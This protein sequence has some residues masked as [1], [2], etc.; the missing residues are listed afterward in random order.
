MPIRQSLPRLRMKTLPLRRKMSR[1]AKRLPTNRPRRHRKTV[2]PSWMQQPAQ[3]SGE[4]DGDAA[5]PLF[6]ADPASDN[7]ADA[8]EEAA[9]EHSAAHEGSEE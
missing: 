7:N 3:P 2:R 5:A 9:E 1:T 4:G 8:T 6:A